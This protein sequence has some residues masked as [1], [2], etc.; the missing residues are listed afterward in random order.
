MNRRIQPTSSL[1]K[2]YINANNVSQKELAELTGYTEKQ[3]SLVLNGK[4]KVSDRFAHALSVAIKGL[5]EDFILRYEEAY[6]KQLLNDQVFLNANNYKELSK[7]YYFSKIFRN[8]TQ[9]PVEQ[10]SLILEAFNLDNLKFLNEV[11]PSVKNNCLFSKDISKTNYDSEVIS[12]WTKI[13]MK[14]LTIGEDAKRFI[15][16]EATRKILEENKELLNVS[17]SSDLVTNLEYIADLCGIHLG[18]SKSAPTTY[19]KGLTFACDDQLFI[20]LTD[21][22]KKVE[23]VVYAFLHEMFHIINGDIT[24]FSSTI[25]VSDESNDVE[26]KANIDATNFLIPADIFNKIKDK[27]NASL[28]DIFN[29][30]QESKSS[31]G[32]VVA[33]LHNETKDYTK[34]WQLLNNFKIEYDMFGN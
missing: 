17:N 31:N 32:L 26:D 29:I 8:I 28:T 22:F 7:K 19:I 5:K 18:F 14:Q 33:R 24:P 13:A 6:Q 16:K 20:I 21:R 9:D 25:R 10:V 2:R 30:A 12:V 15:G 3:V 1:I 4:L 27:N 23:Y 34:F 11:L